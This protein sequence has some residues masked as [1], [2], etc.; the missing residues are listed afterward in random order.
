MWVH[1]HGGDELYSMRL[2]AGEDAVMAGGERSRAP[3]N[4]PITSGQLREAVEMCASVD[5]VCNPEVGPASVEPMCEDQ[6]EQY[7]RD[8]GGVDLTVCMESDVDTRMGV[9]KLEEC[10]G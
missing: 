2:R 3:H 10:A 7:E 6:A 1:V 9:G 8:Q 5:Q 4:K